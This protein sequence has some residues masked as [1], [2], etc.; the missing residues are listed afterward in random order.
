MNLNTLLEKL[1]TAP[2]D[3][4]LIFTSDE[5]DIGSGYHVTEFKLSRVTGID[6]GG[7]VDEWQEAAVQLL[8]GSGGKHMAVGKFAGIL[9]HSVTRVEGL[10]TAP[11]HV[12]FSPGNK[13]LRT[14]QLNEP[15]IKDS[16]V[17]IQL[18]AAG[19]VCK[20]ALEAGLSCINPV[21][22]DSAASGCCSAKSDTE[23]K[24][25]SKRCCG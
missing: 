22:I 12:E 18:N 19:A 16:Q 7:R 6:C 9:Q 21:K 11:V 3:A 1:K 17:V 25:A 15:Q 4:A 23:S 13:G 24:L 14:Y 8:D 20:P 2:A 5:G 10:G